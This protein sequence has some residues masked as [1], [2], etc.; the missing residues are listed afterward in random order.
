MS[1]SEAALEAQIRSACRSLRLPTV[2]ARATTIAAEAAHAGEGHLGFLAALL[3]T[4]LEERTERRHQRLV[5]EAHF[6]RLKRLEDFRFEDAPGVP[7]AQIRELAGLRF[8]ERAE[9]VILVGDS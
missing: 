8:V 4:E 6:P 3:E 1:A 7:A 9:P 2:A 5:A